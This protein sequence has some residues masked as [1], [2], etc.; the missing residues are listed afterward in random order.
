MNNKVAEV[1]SGVRSLAEQKGWDRVVAAAGELLADGHGAKTLVAPAEGVDADAFRRWVAATAG[2]ETSALSLAALETDDWAALAADK[3]IALFECGRLIEAEAVEAVNNAFFTR[4]AASYAIVLCRADRLESEDELKLTLRNAWRL[5]VPD[6]K[7]DWSGQD[8]LER[9]CFLWS[10]AP[11]PDFAAA[12]V[13]RDR[14]ALGAWLGSAPADAEE[15]ERQRALHVLEFADEEV[16][17]ARSEEQG[18]ASDADVRARM[19]ADTRDTLSEVRRRLARRLDADASSIARHITASLQTLE[20]NLLGGLRLHLQDRMP[21]V[22]SFTV[23]ELRRILVSY[24]GERSA[25]WQRKTEEVLSERTREILSDTEELLQSV[26][27]ALINEVA[28]QMGRT[29]VYPPELRPSLTFGRDVASLGVSS[30]R[31]GGPA[32]VN[33]QDGLATAIKVAVGGALATA[34]AATF[35]LLVTGGAAAAVGTFMFSRHRRE[36]LK[37]SEQ[38]GVGFVKEAITTA[39][40]N[41]H[42]QTGLAMSPLRERI[43]GWLRGVED[44]L[45]EALHKTY[46]ASH[47]SQQPADE[48]A[49][50]LLDEYRRRLAATGAGVS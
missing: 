41:V 34:S 1:I 8:L 6:P 4:P 32:R 12:S 30:V 49:R 14:E 10:E 18:G 16:H 46:M 43:T 26:D 13:A 15:L 23:P 27:W 21:A 31:A 37:E 9:R 17:G 47:Q 35:G 44:M 36:R 39:I 29:E 25:G 2:S 20:G 24:V 38:Y 42:E 40:A 50:E 19:L 3:V 33:G 45:D 22:S 11:P 7:P 28:V 48:D 5:L